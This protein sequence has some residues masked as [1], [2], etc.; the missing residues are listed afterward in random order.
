MQQK[1]TEMICFETI[2]VILEEFFETCAVRGGDEK[3]E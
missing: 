3:E 1:Q 2:L